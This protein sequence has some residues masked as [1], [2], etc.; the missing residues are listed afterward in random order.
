MAYAIKGL[1]VKPSYEQL[2]NVAVSD[3]LENIKFPNRDASFLRN[4][5]VLSQLDGEGAR[6]MEHQQ[7]MASKESYKEHLLKEIAKNTGSNLHEL[8][9]ESHQELRAERV[10]Q[11]LNPNPQFFNI[12]QRDHEMETMHSLSSS[13]DTEMRDDMAVSSKTT[14]LPSLDSN[15][16]S[17]DVANQSTAVADHTGEIERQRQIA[18]NERLQLEIR[19]SQQLENIRQQAASVL[20]AT[21]QELTE[22]HRNEAIAYVSNLTE[23]A[24]KKLNKQNQEI[25]QMAS[26]DER[27]RQTITTLKNQLR[28]QEK[29]QETPIRAIP[30]AKTEPPFKFNTETMGVKDAEVKD[31]EKPETT[32]E[33]KGKR[34]RPTNIKKDQLKKKNPDHDTEKDMNRTRTH[35]RKA[36]RQYL[37][38]QLSKHGWRWPKTPDGKNTKPLK[39]ELAQ[40]MILGIRLTWYLMN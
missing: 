37:V 21:T 19:Q 4:G 8:R 38:D 12:S 6:I 22:S 11:A 3:G 34:G 33:P 30:K 16:M 7:E 1:R 10:N 23:N 17:V 40:I 18:E 13:E 5:Y 25:H 20:Q 27:T 29:E 2:I 24:F 14:S 28:N 36:N 39:P 31:D 9:S 26:N 15:A 35:W 32:H